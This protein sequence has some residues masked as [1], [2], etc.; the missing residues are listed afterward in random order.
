M[1]PGSEGPRVD[2]RGRVVNVVGALMVKGGKPP[3]P[4][5]PPGTDVLDAVWV[6]KVMTGGFPLPS[7]V[8][9]DPE[10]PGGG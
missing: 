8:D 2:G 6:L 10:P 4:L 9:E 1:E 3:L 7:V 5:S